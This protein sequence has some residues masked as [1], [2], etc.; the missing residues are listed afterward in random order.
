[1]PFIARVA[2]G[3][4]PFLNVFGNDYPSCDGTGVRDYIHVMDLA[5]GHLAALNFLQTHAGW[6]AVNLG[7]GQGTSVLQVVKAFERISGKSIPYKFAP[8]RPGD[9]ATC[10]AKADLAQQ[11]LHWEASRS[12]EDMCSSTW[13]FQSN[14][15]SPIS[16]KAH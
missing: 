9:V 8:R 3:K 10:Y 12:L 7:T 16:V 14:V 15:T 1:M 2:A 11:L 13:K 6:H 4:M 5:D